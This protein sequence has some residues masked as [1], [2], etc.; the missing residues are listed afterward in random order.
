MHKK[1]ILVLLSGV[2]LLPII[3]L[4]LFLVVLNSV[5]LNQH[6]DSIAEQIS[7][8]LGRRLSLNGTLELNI[9][10][11]SSIVLTD[12]VMANA[13]W[14]SE[15]EMLTIQRVEA[16]IELLALLF[17][18]IRIPRFHLQGV[19]TL[20][21]TD[22][23]GLSNWALAEPLDKELD[24]EE[25]NDTGE[26][27]LPWI[28]DLFISDVEIIFHNGQTGK[29]VM[30]KLDHAR[31]S[32]ADKGS[33]T[34]IDI[35]GQVNNNPV[36][37]R[38]AYAL[39]TSLTEGKTEVPVE[40]HAKVLDF[41]VDATGTITG[42][43]EAPA[44]D[45]MIQANAANLKKLRQ[46][47]GADVPTI[48]KI[49]LNAHLS[50]QNSKLQLSKLQARLGK[51]RIEGRLVLD[52]SAA[53]P[54]LQAELAFSD[55]NLD[56]LL[57]A[58]KKTAERKVKTAAKSDNDRLFSDELLPFEYLSRANLK[59]RLR[60]NN[61]LWNNKRLKEAEI[62]ISLIQGKLSASLLKLSSVR[63]E[64]VGDV[65]VN[66]SGKGTPRVTIKLKAPHVELGE[67]LTL[68]VGTAAVEGPLAT[69]IFLQGQGKSLAQIMGSL[70]GSISLLMEQGRA[71]AKALD[72]YVGGLSAMVG[73]IFID[74]SA[75]TKINCA[76]CDL[77]L[78]DGVL[79]PELAVLD[80]Q[81]STVFADGQVDLKN[82]QLNIEVS[83]VAKGVTLSVAF[84]VVLQ[85]KFS[86]PK[87]E[88]NKTDTLFKSA[89][90]W[91]TIAY[92]PAA[93]LKF[94][95]LRD[96]RSNPCV[97]MV[98]E[99]AGIPIVDDIGEV[100]GGAIKGVGSGIGKIIDTVKKGADS[101]APAEIDAD[102][103]DVNTD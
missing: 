60:A 41:K 59:V 33:L 61:L 26:Y 75:K 18:D 72:L 95:K 2:I 85:G 37:I 84:P 68:S 5:D 56:K 1:W 25:A 79:T 94:E 21:E 30:A 87:I 32:A 81:Y 51:A 54:D 47:F 22:T 82:E 98:A 44:I 100:V 35:V 3:L 42:T 23:N 93:L 89:E 65:V 83:P 36:E 86:K 43:A 76:I 55:L 31:V 16:E 99:K 40:V 8:G 48:G 20:V 70:N 71:D 52:T 92:P 90:L 50:N 103:D 45:L 69:D 14:A 78:K 29:S 80:T 64:V 62:N 13:A 27:K 9:S 46:V 7:E 49:K 57:P 88:V 38:G 10:S 63:G 19:K 34:V 53:I 4:V 17:G 91:A 66:A 15:P 102:E 24:T 96:G 11:T 12:M 67:L 58:G 28:G 97:S 6:K 39:P 101:K 77:Q 73:T 74:Q